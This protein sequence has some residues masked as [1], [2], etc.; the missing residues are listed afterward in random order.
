[1]KYLIAILIGLF[2]YASSG[3]SGN[4]LGED[5]VLNFEKIGKIDKS[6]L[7][8]MKIGDYLK[9]DDKDVYILV[10]SKRNVVIEDFNLIIKYTN[11]KKEI[12][13]K[14]K[15]NIR[16]YGEES[17]ETI[18]DELGTSIKPYEVDDFYRLE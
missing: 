5:R 15:Q 13:R 14:I 4:T 18:F 8:N 12:T 17:I 6:I 3:S 16:L 10:T 1:M 7:I 2:T 11:L 9:I